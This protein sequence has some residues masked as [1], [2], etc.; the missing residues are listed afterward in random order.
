MATEQIIPPLRPQKPPPALIFL[1]IVA[2]EKHQGTWEL[3]C[4]SAPSGRK[5]FP[6]V[7]CIWPSSQGLPGLCFLHMT[8]DP[9]EGA[10]GLSCR[11][12]CSGHTH[13]LGQKGDGT[14]K[15]QSCHSIPCPV[16]G[17][18][19]QE[20]CFLTGHGPVAASCPSHPRM[21]GALLIMCHSGFPFGFWLW[22]GIRA[23][24]VLQA[25]G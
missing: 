19:H 25:W 16:L 4:L 24:L 22:E 1:V 9:K 10:L 3:G 15:S 11:P 8:A 5:L 18:V 12:G 21:A 6:G 17:I 14:C 23:V 20:T 13:S 2:E 7:G